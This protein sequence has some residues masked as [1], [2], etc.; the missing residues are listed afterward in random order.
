MSTSLALLGGKKIRETPFPAYK[1]IGEEEVAAATEVMRSGVLSRFIGA[2]CDDFHGGS[3]VKAFEKEWAAF[4]GTD[5]AIAINSCTSGLNAAVGA[6]GIEHGDEVIVSPYTMS[7]SAVAPLHFG[8]IPV[9]ADIDPD[10]YCLD[11]ASIEDRIT[12]ATRA[13]I[14]VHIFGRPANMDAIMAIAKKYDLKVIEDCAQAPGATYKGKRVGTI[15]DIGVFSFNYHK[16]IHTGEGGMV[17]TSDEKLAHRMQ[18][19]RNHAESV[20]ERMGCTDIKNMVGQNYRMG[21]IEAAIGRRQL[22][23]LTYLLQQRLANVQYLEERLGD[24]P[25]LR[26]PAKEQDAE[27]VYYVHPIAYDESQLGLHRNKIVSAIKAELPDT[28]LREG[29]GGLIGAGYVRPLYLLPLF[30]RQ[31]ALGVEGAPFSSAK[32][33]ISA[34]YQPGVCPHAEYA[35]TNSLITHEMMRPGMSRQDLDDVALAFRKVW[36]NCSELAD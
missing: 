3:Q 15:G 24:L 9:F 13:I 19:I 22:A 7:A 31:I 12:K 18:L 2:W 11:P 34:L 20:V 5:H 4:M 32:R 35:H 17:V 16:H 14:V 21:E 30:Q 1:V 33:D 26:F 25:G 23:K 8:G 6:V 29:E 28:E 36:D 27:H 10:T